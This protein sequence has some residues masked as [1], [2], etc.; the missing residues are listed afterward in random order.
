MRGAVG[1]VLVVA[2]VLAAGCGGSSG[3]VAATASTSSPASSPA[4]AA[5]SAAPTTAATPSAGGAKAAFL[6]QANAICAD[7]NV[8]SDQLGSPPNTVEGLARYFDKGLVLSRTAVRRLRALTPPPGEEAAFGRILTDVDSL[9]GLLDR[10]RGALHAGD[11]AE[12]G[13]VLRQVDA[14]S[15]KVDKEFNAYGLR[16]CSE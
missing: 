14:R 7:L 11:A 15:A 12:A 16:T 6:A 8:A 3:G 9:N 1:A 4:A 2:G 10:A 5:T 13:R